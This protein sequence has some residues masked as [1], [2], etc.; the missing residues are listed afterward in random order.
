MALKRAVGNTLLV[1]VTARQGARLHVGLPLRWTRMSALLLNPPFVSVAV[2]MRDPVG[3]SW[4]AGMLMSRCPLKLLMDVTWSDDQDTTAPSEPAS[5]RTLR[6][7]GSSLLCHMGHK[8]AAHTRTIRPVGTGSEVGLSFRLAGY[9]P[10]L[11][12]LDRVAVKV[13]STP[14]VRLLPSK[15]QLSPC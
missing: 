6:D 5:V 12:R 2:T 14:A 7:K 9:E 15:L 3:G 10:Y 8:R 11:P 4:L 1:A 13:Y